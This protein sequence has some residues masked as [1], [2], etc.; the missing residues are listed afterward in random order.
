MYVGRYVYMYCIMFS[1]LADPVGDGSSELVPI[2]P[3]VAVCGVVYIALMVALGV[4]CYQRH[5]SNAEQKKSSSQRNDPEAQVVTNGVPSTTEIVRS[6]LERGST[7]TVGSGQ[8]W[9]VY[10]A[11]LRKHC[12]KGDESVVASVLVKELHEE[13]FNRDRVM[14]EVKAMKRLHHDNVSALVGVCT[15]QHPY[16]LVTENLDQVSF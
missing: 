16:L 1:V 13:G 15:D 3:I 7:S 9:T 2:V 10:K 12:S 4:W 14:K 6:H 8:Y 11:E 5:A